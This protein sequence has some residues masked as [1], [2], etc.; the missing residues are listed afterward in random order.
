MML[1]LVCPGLL[2]PVPVNPQS[3]PKT[4]T[5]DRLLARADRIVTGCSD[6]ETTV[7]ERFGVRPAPERDAPT[8]SISLLG[9]SL[10]ETPEGYWLHADPVHLRADRDRLLVFAGARIAPSRA[11]ADDLVTLFNSHFGADGLTLTAPRPDRWYLRSERE[12]DLRT[13]PLDRIIGGPIPDDSP[14]G[15]DARRWIGFLNEVQMLF[16]GSEVNRLREQ[17]RR[18][19]IS[20]IWTWGGGVLP[21]P[22]GE[23]PDAVFGDDSLTLGLARWAGVPHRP[24]GQW[25]LAPT[26]LGRADL[27]LWDRLHAALLDRD[28]DAWSI[29]VVELDARLAEVETQIRRGRL[30]GIL[31]DPCEGTAYRLS[32]SALRRFWR[33]GRLADSLGQATADRRR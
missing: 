24:L 2:G 19:A 5:I 30:D 10:G 12:M 11:E 16:F 3:T 32:R 20:G 1:T 4:P 6:P 7:L 23:A 28:L 21:T 13:E 18:P 14:R 9:E 33:R 26:G 29:S 15:G 22:S 25:A 8:A 17:A 31:I 27:V